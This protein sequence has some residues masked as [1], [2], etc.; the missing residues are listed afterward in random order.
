[1][2]WKVWCAQLDLS[3]KMPE[4]EADAG[5]SRQAGDVECVSN[6]AGGYCGLVKVDDALAGADPE[7]RSLAL[8]HFDW[9][10]QSHLH[11]HTMLN[12]LGIVKRKSFLDGAKTSFDQ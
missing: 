6:D 2:V 5:P 1:M 11:T 10:E 7:F 4:S 8:V 3:D 12:L 9:V